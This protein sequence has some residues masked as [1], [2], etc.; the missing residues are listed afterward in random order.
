MKFD[1]F[2]RNQNLPAMIG[3]SKKNHPSINDGLSVP[4]GLA[5]LNNQSKPDSY[6]DFHNRNTENRNLEGGVIREDIY[7]K[8]LNLSDA[9]NKKKSKSKTRRKQKKHRRKTRKI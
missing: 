1:N 2:F 3:G 9:R 5:M 4:L 6:Q 7:N 8:L